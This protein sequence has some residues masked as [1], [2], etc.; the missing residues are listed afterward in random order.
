[1]SKAFTKEDDAIE[2]EK[3]APRSAPAGPFRLTRTG[4]AKLAGSGDPAA[5]AALALAET[6]PWVTAPE[7]AVLGASVRV[8]SDDGE[9]HVYRLVSPEERALL[10][11]G[12][13]VASPIG[14]ALVGARVGD[15]REVA[16]PRGLVEIEVMSIEGEAEAGAEK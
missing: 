11:E 8:A 4:L 1:M 16:L 12:C 7:V 14:R 3:S 15:V 9:T 5:I 6:L 13:S 2:P 10:D